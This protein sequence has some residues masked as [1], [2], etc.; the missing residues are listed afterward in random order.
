MNQILIDFYRSQ[1]TDDQD[2]TL[3]EIFAWT[4]AQWEGSHDMIQWAF[5]LPE[6]SAYNPNAPLLDDETIQVFRTDGDVRWGIEKMLD[7]ATRFFGFYGPLQ[8]R[9]QDAMPLVRPRWFTKNNHNHLRLTRALKFLCLVDFHADAER[10][11]H[12]LLR[13]AAAFPDGVTAT[14]VR[15]WTEA[16]TPWAATPAPR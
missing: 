9:V 13:L 7:R 14:T 6:P 10:L 12:W 2:R 3:N 11:Q 16:V 5:P 1:G 4:D 15:F 8:A